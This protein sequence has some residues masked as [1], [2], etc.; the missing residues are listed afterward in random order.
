MVDEHE[1][2]STEWATLDGRYVTQK[3]HGNLKTEIATQYGELKG[4]LT[5]LAASQKWNRNF[6]IG[7]AIAIVIDLIAA[8]KLLLSGH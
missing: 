8:V 1:R 3:E 4:L 2:S 6:M 5:T 7:V